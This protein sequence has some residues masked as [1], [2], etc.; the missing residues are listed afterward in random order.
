M[1]I[2]FILRSASTVYSYLDESLIQFSLFVSPS[3]FPCLVI[4]SP[5][6]KLPSCHR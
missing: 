6:T 2:L 3:S 5:S 4:L 1:L